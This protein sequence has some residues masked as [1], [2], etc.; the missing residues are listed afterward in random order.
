LIQIAL[1][2]YLIPAL[3]AVLLVG[4]AGMLVLAVARHFADPF[5]QS[6]AQSTRPDPQGDADLE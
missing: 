6:T 1:A 5:H 2:I 3:L 4:A